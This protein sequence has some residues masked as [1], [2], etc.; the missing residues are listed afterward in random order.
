MKRITRAVFICIVAFLAIEV[1]VF[2]VRSIVRIYYPVHGVLNNRDIMKGAQLVYRQPFGEY[3]PAPGNDSTLH[4]L[5]KLAPGKAEEALKTSPALTA[6]RESGHG[7]VTDPVWRARSYFIPHLRSGSETAEPQFQH[8]HLEQT[9]YVPFVT[10]RQT[11][12]AGMN[13]NYKYP[14]DGKD[15]KIVCVNPGQRLLSYEYISDADSS[16]KD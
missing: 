5:Y 1:S 12:C 15:F 3:I 11:K 13:L 7:C 8:S 16:D 2:I 6:C 10:S 4:G 9:I 14:E